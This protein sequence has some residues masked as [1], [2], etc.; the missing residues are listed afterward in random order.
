M[1]S[2]FALLAAAVL[3]LSTPAIAGKNDGAQNQGIGGPT[4]S[5]VSSSYVAP[6]PALIQRGIDQLRAIKASLGGARPGYDKGIAQLLAIC[7]SCH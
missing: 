1:R 6:D 5:S 3:L 7:P 2:R 4:T